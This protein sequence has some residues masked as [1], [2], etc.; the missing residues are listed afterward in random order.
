MV[1][2]EPVPIRLE[3]VNW[4]GKT[5][6]R[7]ILPIRIWRGTTKWHTRPQYFLRALDLED[8]QE[9]DF[10]MSGFLEWPEEV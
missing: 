6:E 1:E 5:R 7:H 9:K 8:Q 4:Q 3:Y 2:L 10:A